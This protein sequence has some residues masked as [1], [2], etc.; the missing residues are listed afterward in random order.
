MITAIKATTI[1]AIAK[2]ALSIKC[3]LITTPHKVIVPYKWPYRVDSLS[4]I[5]RIIP[6]YLKVAI[7]AKS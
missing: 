2:A 6:L 5:I 4:L 3:K 7:N 1:V